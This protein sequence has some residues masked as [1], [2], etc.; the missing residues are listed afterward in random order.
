M[1]LSRRQLHD[2]ARHGAQARM[3]ELESEIAAIRKAFPDA[4][5]SPRG[6]KRAVGRRRRKMSA[7]AKKAVSR[8]MK[9]YW[10]ARKAA[11]K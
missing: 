10:K 8:R 2:L 4:G 3:A 1:A 7:A 11:T 6:R 5:G 9:A